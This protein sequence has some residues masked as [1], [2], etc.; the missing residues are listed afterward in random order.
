MFNKLHDRKTFLRIYQET[1]KLWRF[2][3]ANANMEIVTARFH[4]FNRAVDSQIE[5]FFFEMQ[6]ILNRSPDAGLS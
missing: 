3:V 4:R 6:R 2:K 5:F 1:S